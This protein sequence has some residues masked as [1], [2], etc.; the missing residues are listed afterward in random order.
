MSTL[1]STVVAVRDELIADRRHLHAN[2]E[3]A[4][5]EHETAAYVAARL[6]S[7]AIETQ[8]GVGGT[9]VKGVI[10][11]GRA[12]RTVMLRADMDALPIQ[13]ESDKP[14]KSTRPGVMHA[15]GHDGHT[16]ILLAV[17][18]ILAARP[19]TL[20]G[21]VVLCFQPAEERP[22]GGAIKM[23]EDGVMDDPKVDAVFGLHLSSQAVG[24]VGM[25]GGASQASADTFRAEIIGVGGHAA[26][27]HAAVDPVLIAANVVTTLHTI[28]SREVDPL[29][30]AVITVGT[31]QAGTVPNVIPR[32]ATM[33]GTV[34]TLDEDVRQKLAKRIQET[35]VG[36]A[37]AMGGD[38]TVDYAFGY[39]VLVNDE[40]MTELVRSVAHEVVGEERTRYNHPPIM[41]SEDVGYF[42]SRA[43]GCYF[44][45]GV[46]NEAKGITVANHN[47][48]FDIDEDALPVGVAMLVRIVDR[49]LGQ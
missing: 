28:V 47:P 44:N 48:G 11:G 38:A 13:E 39:P 17:A 49:Y 32:S 9:G 29:Q 18:R 42:I 19:E 23:I 2:P 3:L 26:R 40:A 22:P 6:R 8:T 35:I 33:S 37:R 36:I 27:P 34:R 4:F 16:A 30:S 5:E 12:G 10:R 20:A 45:L 14:Y 7:L 21:N 43:T 1:T 41:P 25:R 15:C 46:L 24:T 31:I